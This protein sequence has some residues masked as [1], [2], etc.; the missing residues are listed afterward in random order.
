MT[1]LGSMHMILSND[2]GTAMKMD[3]DMDLVL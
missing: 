2:E 1:K 3:M